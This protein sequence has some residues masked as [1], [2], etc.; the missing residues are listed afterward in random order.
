MPFV[1]TCIKTKIV[2]EHNAQNYE[3]GF[4]KDIGLTRHNDFPLI[5]PALRL[6]QQNYYRILLS[7]TKKAKKF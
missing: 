3:K 2:G 5:G 1:G 4:P 7:I 6:F